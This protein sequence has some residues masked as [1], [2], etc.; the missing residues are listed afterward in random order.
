MVAH[1]FNAI[2]L[3]INSFVY[4]AEVFKI[5]CQNFIHNPLVFQKSQK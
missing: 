2:A 5:K 1:D 3:T 4:G